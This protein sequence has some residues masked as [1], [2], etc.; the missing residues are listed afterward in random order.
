MRDLPLQLN[1]NRKE[2]MYMNNVDARFE[3]DRLIITIDVSEN[4]VKASSPTKTGKTKLVASSH[5][6]CN[7]ENN[8]ILNLNLMK[9]PDPLP[10]DDGEE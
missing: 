2:K 4:R 8:F 1:P 9:R 7:I 6:H 3:G 5:G 10:V